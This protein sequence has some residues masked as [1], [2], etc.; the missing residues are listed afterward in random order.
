M[1]ALTRQFADHKAAKAAKN[2]ART[3]TYDPETH[4]TATMPAAVTW[5]PEH[6]PI[7]KQINLVIESETE[8]TLKVETNQLQRTLAPSGS[9]RPLQALFC[10]TIGA[11]LLSAVSLVRELGIDGWSVLPLGLILGSTIFYLVTEIHQ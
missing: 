8:T 11:E 6:D 7:H 5:D 4:L 3:N 2:A 10:C 1:N 9:P